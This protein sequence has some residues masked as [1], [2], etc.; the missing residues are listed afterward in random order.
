VLDEKPVRVTLV[1]EVIKVVR[2]SPSPGAA[3]GK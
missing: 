1:V 3:P 2:R